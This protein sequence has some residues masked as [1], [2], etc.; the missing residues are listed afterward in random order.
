MRM[1]KSLS[2]QRRRYRRSQSRQRR[3]YL[4]T[5]TMT[6]LS[7][8]S[9]KP[10]KKRPRRICSMMKTISLSQLR[11]HNQKQW[12]NQ[13]LSRPKSLPCL[14][15]KTMHQRSKHRQQSQSLWNNLKSDLWKKIRQFRSL[16]HPKRRSCSMMMIPLESQR[17][18]LN[19][20]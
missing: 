5:M 7:S 14:M 4:A 17:L 3:I 18:R 1:T 6:S 15:M 20:R 9:Q 11:R 2:F 16:S 13:K 10:S 12:K 8:P 19:Q